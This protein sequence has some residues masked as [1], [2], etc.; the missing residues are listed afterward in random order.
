LVRVLTALL[1]EQGLEAAEAQVVLAEQ[2]RVQVLALT[3]QVEMVGLMVAA[4]VAVTPLATVDQ[5]V[6]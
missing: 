2:L 5:V 1:E 6:D 3:A 4:V